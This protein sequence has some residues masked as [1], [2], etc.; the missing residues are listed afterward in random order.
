MHMNAPCPANVVSAFHDGTA[1][2]GPHMIV[3]RSVRRKSPGD[4]FVH[5]SGHVCGEVPGPARDRDSPPRR[6]VRL[7]PPILV[8]EPGPDGFAHPGL[9]PDPCLRDPDAP[10]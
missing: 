10:H 2:S 6:T 7:E 3:K 1:V 8:A 5:L 4:P 9:P